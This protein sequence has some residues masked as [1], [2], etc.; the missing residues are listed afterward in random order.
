MNQTASSIIDLAN[1]YFGDF[2]VRGSEVIAEY[3]PFCHGGANEDRYTFAVNSE[4]GAFNC[5]RGSCNESGALPKLLQQ[6]GAENFIQIQRPAAYVKK[7]KTFEKPPVDMLKPLTED[8]ITYFAKRKISVETLHDFNVSADENGNIVFPFYRGGDLT[9]VK[10]RKPKKHTKED[11]P[12]EW[13]MKNTEPILFGMDNVAFNR[14]LVITEGEIDALSV[15]E[16]GYHNV[17]SVPCGCDDLRFL[18]NCGAWLEKF[19]QFILLGDNDQAGIRMISSLTEEL[20]KDKCL[21]PPDYPALI[22]NG[23][24][25]NRPCK[26]ANEILAFY[27]PEYLMEIIESCEKAPVDGILNLAD[28]PFVDPTTIPR[29]YSMI[30]DLDDTIGGFAEGTLT[31]V[32]GKRGD[33]KSTFS[34]PILLNAIQQGY[35][36]A[37]YSGELPAS[38]FLEW[39]ML[40]A[41]ERNYIGLKKDPRSGKLFPC[42]SDDIQA[43]IRKWLDNKFYLFDNKI[44]SPKKTETQSIL[45]RFA[46]CARRYGCKMFLVDN[47]MIALRS[48]A[49]EENRAQANFTAELK[50]FAT[51]YNVCVIMVAHPR[52][53]KAGE[54]FTNDDVSGSSAITNLADTVI[55]ISRPN[56]SVVKNREFGTSAMIECN[57]DP[58][59]RR[60]YQLTTGDRTVYGWD[61][62]G[63]AIPIQRACEDRHFN[64]PDGYQRV[65]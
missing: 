26:D 36:V 41:T 8:I 37:A 57:Y 15:Y 4:N 51:K 25:F 12:K 61:H 55:N 23:H 58:C 60:I 21:V 28:I 33:G 56:I 59:N 38:R 3:C 24:D 20:G 1:K 30:P 47:L 49:E 35:S 9:F 53:Q 45:D 63:I 64:V 7:N 48:A 40:Q 42:V 46:I 14:P 32:S 34:G 18:D 13:Q 54:A 43:R 62:D 52:K 17:V 44:V 16:A 19:S 65:I 27:G 50:A 22:V 11:G 2:K 39:I 5:K 31:I 6:L 29:I 10:Y